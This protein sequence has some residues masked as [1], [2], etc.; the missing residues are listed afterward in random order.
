M[1]VEGDP[2]GASAAAKLLIEGFDF[3]THILANF[4][5]SSGKKT[6]KPQ[7]ANRQLFVGKGYTGGCGGFL[8]QM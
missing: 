2:P 1:P 3:R 5:S 6:P 7:T 8:H 4:Q